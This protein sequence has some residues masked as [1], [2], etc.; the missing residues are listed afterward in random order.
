MEVIKYF[1]FK[2]V[3]FAVPKGAELKEGKLD[4]DSTTVS[5]YQ[6]W[7]L[8]L[9]YNMEI[10]HTVWGSL[11]NAI[12]KGV[13]NLNMG[14]EAIF[15]AMFSLLGWDG[16]LSSSDSPLHALY[17]TLNIIGW[18]LLGLALIVVVWQSLGHE[19][20]WGKILPNVILVALTITVLPL[21]MRT[22]GSVASPATTDAGIGDIVISAKNDV[23]SS[24][25]GT[26]AGDIAIQPIKNNIVDLARVANK[27]WKYD[28]ENLDIAKTNVINDKN[29][30]RSLNLGQTMDKDTIKEFG[31]DD[32]GGNG[33]KKNSDPF[34]YYLNDDSTT[35]SG[36]SSFFWLLKRE[37]PAGLGKANDYGYTRYSVNWLPMYGQSIIL[38][39]VLIVAAF[40]VTK[41]IFEL[42]LMN[43]VAPVMAYQSVRD[44]KKLRDLINSIVGLYIS[45]VLM[46]LVIRVFFIFVGSAPSRLPDTLN[47]FQQ[48]IATMIIYAAGGY[49]LFAG[50]SYFERVTGVSQ[51]FG[52]ETSHLGSSLMGAYAGT[53]MARMG[54][55]AVGS[56]ISKASKMFSKSDS[57]SKGINTNNSSNLSEPKGGGLKSDSKTNNDQQSN[58]HNGDQNN[59]ANNEHSTENN[60]QTQ[61]NSDNNSENKQTNQNT[62]T[63]QNAD[64]GASGL[65]DG[66][67]TSINGDDTALNDSASGLSENT[68]GVDNDLI[69]NDNDTINQNKE[70]PHNVT[71]INNG[72]EPNLGGRGEPV[73]HGNPVIAP[74]E[75]QNLSNNIPRGNNSANGGTI[76]QTKRPDLNKS[77][78]RVSLKTT[79]LANENGT[80]T[81][82]AGSFDF[83]KTGSTDYQNGNSEQHSDHGKQG[84]KQAAGYLRNHNYGMSQRGHSNGVDADDID[85]D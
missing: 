10:L 48:G 63:P 81:E 52:D 55:H 56:G 41:D 72:S 45:L 36:E 11:C 69:N 2:L 38:F 60:N 44:S 46:F 47:W 67:D 51:G 16:T 18:A 83:S 17:V 27:S 25:G 42:T 61:Q 20:K 5:W 49:A 22:A 62:E 82:G 80:G 70:D 13:Y 4:Y 3:F 78:D 6:H 37:A 73:V 7:S 21:V 23:D 68:G 12:V 9:H 57:S 74:T 64:V 71:N 29:S 39:V 30:I 75:K 84:F 26:T 54:A 32:S 50:V 28:P 35:A 76:S 8:Y 59:K 65:D 79:P 43:L 14:V 1:L 34:N 33:F 53:Q 40:R 58:T 85:N 31:L 24:K 66:N 15:N 19:V 77:S